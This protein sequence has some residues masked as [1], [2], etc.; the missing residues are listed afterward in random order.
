MCMYSCMSTTFLNGKKNN[1]NCNKH[2]CR[3]ENTR[4]LKHTFE[5]NAKL[6][7]GI[8]NFYTYEQTL[9]SITSV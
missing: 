5:R 3:Q 4:H 6:A 1:N 9:N 7:L 8:Y 2:L